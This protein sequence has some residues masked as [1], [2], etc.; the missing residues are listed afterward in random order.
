MVRKNLPGFPTLSLQ[1]K[2]WFQEFREL[3][4]IW[5]VKHDYTSLDPHLWT[6]RLQFR[7]SLHMYFILLATAKLKEYVRLAGFLLLSWW[8]LSRDRWEIALYLWGAC[9]AQLDVLRSNSEAQ[10]TILISSEKQPALDSEPTKTT[11]STRLLIRVSS[12]LRPLL[13]TSSL[14]FLSYANTASWEPAPGY[15]F[16]N[17]VIPS[18]WGPKAKWYPAVGTIFIPLP[19]VDIPNLL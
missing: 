6:T 17:T 9:I 14:Y 12:I 4:N 2:F 15:A 7:A 16:L 18:I 3:T 8:Y 19:H 10:N 11:S 5:S 13:F 1:P